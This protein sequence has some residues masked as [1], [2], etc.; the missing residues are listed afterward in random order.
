M[1]NKAV[2]LDSADPASIEA[3]PI[4]PGFVY[5]PGV[6]ENYLSTPDAPEFAI[7]SSTICVVAK[8][9][10]NQG[11]W[12]N[13][14]PQ[15]IAA[16]FNGLATGSWSFRL[17][18]T[19]T[20]SFMNVYSTG[21]SVSVTANIVLNYGGSGQ[22]P[23]EW[24]WVAV[25]YTGE[26]TKEAKFWTSFDGSA[27][28]QLGGTLT[29]GSTSN[30]LN[31]TSPLWIGQF[32]PGASNSHPFNGDIG[33]VSVRNGVGAGNTV[34]GT[35]VFRFDGNELTDAAATSFTSASGHTMTVNKTAEPKLEITPKVS[36]AVTNVGRWLDRSGNNRHF[37]YKGVPP[38]H[39]L[40]SLNGM[41]V[42]SFAG[43]GSLSR[44]VYLTSL[45]DF[46]VAAV[47]YTVTG[48]E[49]RNYFETGQN[50]HLGCTLESG[51]AG[52]WG[53]HIGGIAWGDASP[54]KTNVWDQQT[55]YRSTALGHVAA[56]SKGVKLG[57]E[58]TNGFVAAQYRSWMGGDP[59][60]KLTCWIAELVVI[61][62]T[63]S[64]DDR[65]KLES[66]LMTKWGVS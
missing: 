50:S 1:P 51:G 62:G 47:V 6:L 24:L 59:W 9:R 53:W 58:Q 14:L 5:L 57:G 56:R 33:H 18:N 10:T 23:G 44:P 21:G 54:P 25:A 63:W 64:D 43:N 32:K 30:I 37:G 15:T 22:T 35:E 7:T 12:T 45:T 34:G 66:Y 55:V 48:S 16:K 26:G 13:A 20:L 39:G 46:L 11:V 4:G 52:W 49:K 40:Y 65:T 60:N 3:A 28:T 29:P 19:G 42:V 27:W 31:G 61:D 8:I 41:P 2:W 38:R 36:S 17:M